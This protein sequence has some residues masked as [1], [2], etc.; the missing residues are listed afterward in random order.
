[1]GGGEA[2]G[3]RQQGLNSLLDHW[4]A[5]VFVQFNVHPG[6]GQCSSAT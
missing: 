6:I 1:M 5:H 2:G 3:R 4:S